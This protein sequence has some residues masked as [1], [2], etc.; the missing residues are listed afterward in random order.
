MNMTSI[1]RHVRGRPRRRDG[2]TLL[3]LLTVILIIGLLASILMPAISSVISGAYEAL[4][5]ARIREL[6]D[7]AVLYHDDFNFYPGQKYPEQLI[8]SGGNYTGT[9]VLMACLWGYDYVN[10]NVVI[11]DDPAGS[12][13]V[14]QPNPISEY[15]AIRKVIRRVAMQ[16]AATS[17]EI[18]DP[19]IFGTAS[20]RYNTFLDDFPAPLP[21][22]YYPMRKGKTTPVQAY[23]YDDNKDYVED[24]GIFGNYRARLDKPAGWDLTNYSAEMRT[25]FYGPTY[26]AEDRRGVTRPR[27]SEGEFLLIGPGRDR[28]YMTGDDVKSWSD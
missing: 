15:A 6:S 13:N 23:L 10:I 19:R 14:N 9:Q 28:L 7:G 25:E 12:P 4:T 22:L 5:V 18:P 3:E 24:G 8:G 11:Q 17:I 1:Q 27:T 26:A 16:G 21:I 20:G 2:F